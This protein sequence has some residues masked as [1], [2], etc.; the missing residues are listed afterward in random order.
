MTHIWSKSV[1]LITAL[2]FSFITS[3]VASDNTLEKPTPAEAVKLLQEGNKRF[4][5]GKPVHPHTSANRIFQAGVENQGDHAFATVITCSDSRVPVERIFDTG[6]MDTF[7]IRVAGNV[8][9]T[10]EAGSVEYGLSHVHTP[11]LVVLG[12]TQCGAVTAVTHSIQGKGH[13]LER[14][15]P[16]LV[17]NIIPAVKRTMAE[18]PDVHGDDIIPLAIVENVWQGIEDLFMNSPSSRDLYREGK[19]KVVGAV[20]DVG[21]GMV[22]WLSEEPVQRIFAQI[23]A[24][25][26]RQMEAMASGGHGDSATG[27]GQGIHGAEASRH[28]AP[29]HVEISPAPVSLV[30][31]GT[32]EILQTESLKVLE[33]AEHQAAH[34]GLSGTFWVIV[35][36]LAALVVLFLLALATGVFKKVKL[37]VKMYASFGGLLLLALLLGGGGY[38]N[39]QNVN[40]FAHLDSTFLKLDANVN[41][42]RAAQNG[43]ILH[44]L[45]NKEFGEDLLR[46]LDEDIASIRTILKGVAGNDRLDS[47]QQVA[48]KKLGTEIDEYENRLGEVVKAFH[49]IEEMNVEVRKAE[50]NT[51]HQLELI[52]QHHEEQL[53]EAEEK[54]TDIEEIVRQTIIVEH[55]LTLETHLLKLFHAKLEF[56]LEKSPELIPLME[57]EFGF[58]VAYLQQIEH[59]INNPQE[60]KQLEA[61]Q[62]VGK[63]YQAALIKMIRDEAL[64]MQNMGELDRLITEFSLET[65]ALSH[66]METIAGSRVKEA[67]TTTLMLNGV[68][69]VAGILLALYLT[70]MIT[71]PVLKSVDFAQAIA[72]GD[73]TGELVVDQKDEIGVLA[74]ALSQMNK[75]LRTMMLDIQRGATELNQSS[76]NVNSTANTM[77]V[78]A[79]QTSGAANSVATAA[80]EM[81]VNM[82]SVASA[83]EEAATNVKMVAAA[84]EEMTGTIS[85]ITQ[86]TSKT[87]ELTSQA[88]EQASKA[89]VKVDELGAAAEAISKVTETITEISEQTNLLALNATIE[90]ARAG[91]A[92]KGF[93]VVA[94]EIKELAKQTAEATLEIKTKIEGVQNSTSETVAEIKGIT[95]VIDDVNAMTSTIAA[96]IE[97]Q[98]TA[99]QE[100][101]G[102]VSQAA[103]G[104]Q[105]VTENVAESSTVARDISS[106]IAEIDQAASGLKTSSAN[107][108]S[109]ANQLKS[110]AQ[111]L[112]EMVSKFKV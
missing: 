15:I 86:T 63:E 68:M 88:V 101:A 111:Q 3:V 40:G 107:L 7:I 2:L 28:A 97:E 80:E 91:E 100:I 65:E 50:K 79:D 92:G 77:A 109:S 73:L 110:F 99:T 21:T 58:T 31:A 72:A 44:G 104:I 42:V 32:M 60:K 45:E 43:F 108:L 8:M 66:E 89:S 105:E 70:W 17:D 39:L 18:H 27:H 20:Y 102:N 37:R 1:V 46:Q 54:G 23:E 95:K 48:V 11:V 71:S 87:S 14:N 103:Q 84:S 9:D 59:E 96:A 38:I 22:E 90:A 36:I 19:V 81:S 106:D 82:T 83:A 56:L 10:D 41:K 24:N 51:N 78:N 64:I 25:P 5:S 94:N 16:P 98:T 49:E 52:A 53:R 30:E 62:E 26:A 61:V 33:K 75:S 35:V 69:L 74:G 85:E 12:H 34:Y 4:Y 47:D 67:V 6:I 29:A 55:L 57:Q 112:G 13:G 93:A 76:D